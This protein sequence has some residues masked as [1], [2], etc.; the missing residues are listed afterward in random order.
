VNG[1]YR[2][3]DWNETDDGLR[4]EKMKRGKRKNGREQIMR[5]KR[6]AS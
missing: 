3:S 5:R 1:I 2:S 4:T 6:F